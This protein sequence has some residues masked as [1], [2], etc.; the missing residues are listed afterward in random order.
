M[1]HIWLDV[2][3]IILRKRE[4]E[5]KREREKVGIDATNE[6]GQLESMSRDHTFIGSEAPAATSGLFRPLISNQSWHHSI[7]YK[8]L[9]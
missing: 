6:R 5:R 2:G 3:V 9:S 4:A 7:S 8:A 1:P